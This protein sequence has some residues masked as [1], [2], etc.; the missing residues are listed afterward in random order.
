MKTDH[1][2]L[3]ML[4][5]NIATA[6]QSLK[7]MGGTFKTNE[8]ISFFTQHVPSLWNS[9][10]Q[11]I[12]RTTSV[13]GKA[14]EVYFQTPSLTLAKI[15]VISPHLMFRLCSD[16]WTNCKKFGPVDAPNSRRIYCSQIFPQFCYFCGFY[17]WVSFFNVCFPFISHWVFYKM[18]D[19]CC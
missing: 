13:A 8:R 5:P 1:F 6:C 16:L 4:S 10:P 9:L 3:S 7:L 2:F 11:K 15:G 12:I 14:T 18:A 17:G 19:I